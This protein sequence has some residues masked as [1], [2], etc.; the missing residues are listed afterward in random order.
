MARAIRSFELSPGS[1]LGDHYIIER[2]IGAGTEGE[3]YQIRERGTGI[4]RAAKLY[5]PQRNPRGQTSSKLAR[6]L[7]ALRHCSIVLHYH[8]S[9]R[10]TL[11]DQPVVA[12]ISEL[13]E[14]EPL[15][16][17]INSHRGKRLQSYVALHVLWNLARGLETIHSLGQYHADVHSENILIKPRGI[18]FDLKLIDFYDW[19][20]P[21]AYKRHQD[22][23]DA[24]RVFHECLGGRARYAKLPDEVKYICAGLRRDLI[25]KRFPTI[26]ALRHHLDHFDWHGTP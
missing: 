16:Q 24:I 2:R 5:F 25:R 7:N 19:G 26:T 4:R 20:A 9:E 10:L 12:M 15:A 22:I 14:G 6:K 8:H 3:V 1:R 13:C 17:W 23:A 11:D 18:R 21:R